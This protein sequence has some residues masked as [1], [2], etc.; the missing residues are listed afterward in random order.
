M[1]MSFVNS[2]IV[3]AASA[4]VLVHNQQS[5]DSTP[6]DIKMTR[7]LIR[8]GQ[9]FN[10]EAP[11]HVRYENWVLLQLTYAPAHACRS[12]LLFSCRPPFSLEIFCAFSWPPCK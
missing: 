8:V 7:D 9:L 11:N 4:I 5:G 12:F 2:T 3:A 1:G 10:I 6:S